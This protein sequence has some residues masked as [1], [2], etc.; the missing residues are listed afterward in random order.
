MSSPTSGGR[1]RLPRPFYAVWAS[2]TVSGI[3]DGMRLVALP[4]LTAGLTDDARQ[5]TLVALAGQLPWLLLS[6]AS[7]ALSD[8][9]ERRRILCLVDV[10]RAAVMAGLALLTF[11]DGLSIPVLAGVAFLLGCGQTLYN[12]AWSGIVPA[13]VPPEGLTRA[14]ARLQVSP[15]LAGPM[16][17]TPVGA[18]LFAVTP[19]LPLTVDA[20]SYACSAGLILLV[21]GSARARPEEGVPTRRSLRADVLQGLKWLWG[22]RLLRELC[23][24]AAVGNLVV[25]GLMSVLVLYARRTLGLEGP[26]YAVLMV[27]YAVGG[28]AGVPLAPLLEAR[29]GARRVL[30]IGMPATALLCAG[31]GSARSVLVAAVLIAVYGA[32]GLAWNVTAV[33]LRQ[34]EVPEG[35]LGRVSMSFQMTNMCA[36]ALGT[37]LAGL[38]YQGIGPRAPFLAGAVLLCLCGV[39]FR[40]PRAGAPAEAAAAV[41]TYR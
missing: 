9:F 10:A 17:G 5:V 13:V 12:G 20:V 23:A 39:C 34:S 32:V 30:R 4:L 15:L 7:G 41:P 19:V 11:V 27:A 16:L 26:G 21:A 18:V 2:V 25:V 29:I 3:G 24:V 33:S 1:D 35:L 22:H 28:I 38:A 14:N 36:G 40:R 31:I 6:L 8:R 37:L